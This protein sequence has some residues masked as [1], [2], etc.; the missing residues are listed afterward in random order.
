M[1]K[2][3]Y[4][5]SVYYSI[6]YNIQKIT[7]TSRLKIGSSQSAYKPVPSR[8]V[9]VAKLILYLWLFAALRSES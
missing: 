6:A 8:L 2:D 5:S 9:R 1:T 7:K 4:P 3:A